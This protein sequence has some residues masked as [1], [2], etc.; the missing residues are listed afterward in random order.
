MSL[1][2]DSKE[3]LSM[4]VQKLLEV[5]R[6]LGVYVTDYFDRDRM[7]TVTDLVVKARQAAAS[8]LAASDQ[9]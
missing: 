3:Q 9:P 8:C 7:K 6:I 5:E 1:E 2:Q 4:A